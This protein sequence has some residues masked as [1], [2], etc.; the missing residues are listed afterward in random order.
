MTKGILTFSSGNGNNL[1]RENTE[2]DLDKEILSLRPPDFSGY[3]GQEET[4]IH[5]RC[6][7]NRSD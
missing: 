3:V 2:A 7:E 1:T 4:G 6:N 5:T